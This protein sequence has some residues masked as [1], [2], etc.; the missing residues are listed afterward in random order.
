MTPSQNFIIE[1]RNLSAHLHS[2]ALDWGMVVHLS[3][4]YVK[5]ILPPLGRYEGD[6]SDVIRRMV[7]DAKALSPQVC[8]P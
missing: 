3:D 4:R 6:P 2:T 5:V 8:R 1:L 7:D